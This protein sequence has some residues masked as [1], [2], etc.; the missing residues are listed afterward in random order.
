MN[1]TRPVLPCNTGM[2]V[3]QWDKRRPGADKVQQIFKEQFP[4]ACESKEAMADAIAKTLGEC[5][6]LKETEALAHVDTPAHG[7][8]A[9]F[10]FQLA[11]QD[12]CSKYVNVGGR[13]YSYQ[14]GYEALV[15]A[16]SSLFNP[17][18]RLCTSA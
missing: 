15:H 1:L 4:L 3:A 10:R 6:D 16:L 17:R 9:F 5:P 11:A 8:I 2:H 12:E 7:R 14:L 13:A 18:R